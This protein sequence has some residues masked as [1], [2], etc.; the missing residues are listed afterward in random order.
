[1][2]LKSNIMIPLQSFSSGVIAEI[3]RRQPA[4]KERTNFAWQLAVGPALAR[5]TTVELTDGVLTVRA[6]D[7]RWIQEIDRAKVNVM[8]KL[9]NILGSDQVTRIVTRALL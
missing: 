7:R 8:L 1:L 2:N 4:S 9:Q 5:A 3:V 6:V